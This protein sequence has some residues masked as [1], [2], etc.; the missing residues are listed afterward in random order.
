MKIVQILP[1]LNV[2]GVETG[3]VDLARY[4]MEHG[5]QALVISNGGALV[6]ELERLGVLHIK[7]A[8]NKKNIWT[9]FSCMRKLVKI[10]KAENADIVHARSRVP[11]WIAFWACRKTK[12]PFITTCHGYYSR[13]FFS[14]VMAWGRLVI[15][16]SQVI[17][18]HMIE[19]FG[20][21]PENIRLIPRSVD[22]RKYSFP[23]ED[24]PKKSSFIVA[25]V[26]RITPLKGHGYF[27]KAMARVLRETPYVR[28]WVIGDAP[29]HKTGYKEELKILTR[30]LGLADKVEF[31]GNRKDIP[32]L[33]AQTDVL[34][35]SSVVPEAFGRVIIEAQAAGVAVVATRIG[36]VIEI[37]EDGKTGI[38][39]EPKNPA[40][41]AAGITRLLKERA[42][43]Q[44]LA[45][46]AREKLLSLYTL[47]HMAG[48]TVA[49]YEEVLKKI[50]ILVIK[51]SALGDIVLI[52][53]SLK[54]LRE[55]FPL[56]HITCLVRKEFREVLQRCPYLDD[57]I[58]YDPLHR[59]SGF[60]GFLKIAKRLRRSKFDKIVDFQNNHK[61]HLL[62][63]LSSCHERYG[64]N[65]K[66]WGFLLNFAIHPSKDV[67]AAVDHQ[68]QV[69]KLLGVSSTGGERLELWPSQED[70]RYVRQLLDGQ[71]ISEKTQI[72]GIHLSASLQWKTKSW[73]LEHIA[74]LCDIL[75]AKNI[76]TVFTGT[77]HDQVFAR[78]LL[79]LTKA[80]PA[81]F[82]GKT[83]ILQLAALIKRC[84]AFVTPDSAPMH[85]SAAVGTPFVALFGPTDPRRHL[86]PAG[87]YQLMCHPIP[88]APCYRRQCSLRK[89]ICLQDIKPVD[90]GVAI[91]RLMEVQS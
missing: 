56:A 62:A 9:A 44:S 83:S 88:C 68:F 58:V 70:K 37:I 46:N 32:E 31:L 33:L 76:R 3:T 82:T 60:W 47:D 21:S 64:H 24:D 17:G 27:L 4:L 49:V 2:G 81:D 8:V 54:A 79:K 87:K 50:K 48:Q 90:V 36:G 30:R 28:I 26:G 38:L 72:V 18:R 57:V 10:L 85:I 61:S 73:P 65:N 25:I 6:S 1:E 53:P 40:E 77:H 59:H 66:K 45:K 41:M 91:E 75:A 23:R 34:A 22:L 20:V 15:V 78:K 42:F 19:C 84:Q 74:Q 35:F 52:T 11:A 13:H 67:Y 14:K 16:P 89:S 80:K 39:V 55:R 69:L 63:F 7:L 43:A 12:T 51:L 86:P 5:H 71:W 29:A